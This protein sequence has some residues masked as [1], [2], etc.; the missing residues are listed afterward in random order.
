MTFQ[1]VN[2]DQTMR[3][4]ISQCASSIKGKKHF[5]HRRTMKNGLLTMAVFRRVRLRA[6]LT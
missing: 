2:R 3:G 4:M 1:N 6:Q 5:C